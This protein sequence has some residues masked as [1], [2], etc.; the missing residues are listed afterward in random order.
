MKRLTFL[1]AAF[2]FTMLT[3]SANA[4]ALD[5]LKQKTKSKVNQRV[6][7]KVDKAIDKTL[8][9]AEN[10]AKNDNTKKNDNTNT[11]GD[12]TPKQVS[13]VEKGPPKSPAIKTYQNYDFVPGDKILFEDHFTDEQDGEFPSHWELE[14]GQ[15]VLN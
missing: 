1:A 15:A 13:S 4:Q 5:K 2:F 11:Q 9:G 3:L 10:A 6:D 8:D 12:T 14:K 7:E